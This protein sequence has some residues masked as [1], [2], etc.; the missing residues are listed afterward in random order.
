ME[1]NEHNHI[2]I[3]YHSSVDKIITSF[4]MQYIPSRMYS[5]EKRT[6]KKFYPAF[7][8]LICSINSDMI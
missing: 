2:S 8:R 7:S 3:W 5:E 6:V 1:R 4:K